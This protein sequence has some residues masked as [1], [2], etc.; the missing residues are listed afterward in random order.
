MDPN[1]ALR[2][3]RPRESRLSAVLT[4]SHVGPLAL[5]TLFTGC[6]HQV[7]LG[8]ASFEERECAAFRARRQA[9]CNS[10]ELRHHLGPNKSNAQRTR[11]VISLRKEYG[12][13]A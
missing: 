4:A 7:L 8:A 10:V 3:V 11:D 6:T 2:P 9:Q 13:L 1:A 12:G 5:C